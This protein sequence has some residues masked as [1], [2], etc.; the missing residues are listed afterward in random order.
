MSILDPFIDDIVVTESDPEMEMLFL[1]ANPVPLGRNEAELVESMREL[2]CSVLNEDCIIN[3]YNANDWWV[4]FTN[5][6]VKPFF[7]KTLRLVGGKLYSFTA[8]PNEIVDI[9]KK[10]RNRVYG[11][12]LE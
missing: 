11:K 3:H 7:G 12:L 1:K 9:K 5:E 10:L 8:T 6:E 2:V 4:T